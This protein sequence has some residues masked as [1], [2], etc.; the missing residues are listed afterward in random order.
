MPKAVSGF[1]QSLAPI[2]RPPFD[3]LALLVVLYY[4]WCFLVY[5]H[6][7]I[8]RGNLPDL[9]DYMYLTQL[10][11]W[12]KGQGW[13]DNI[14][15]RLNPPDGVPIHFSRLAMLPMAA[16]TLLFHLFG[17][18][19]KGAALLMSIIYPLLLLGGLLV[20]LRWLAESFVPQ[21][22]T[23]VTAYIALFATSMLYMFMLGHVDHHG[24]VIILI[25]ATLIFVMRMMKEPENPR[26]GLYAGLM[27]AFALTVA[28]EVLPWLLIIAG[29]V[30]IWATAKGRAAAYNGLAFALA[31]Y[32]GS[33]VFLT[34]TRPPDQWFVT[35]VLTYSVV[36]VLL[37]AGI[38]VGFAGVAATANAKSPVRWVVGAVLACLT[39]YLFLH[40]FPELVTGPYGGMDPELAEQLLVRDEINEVMPLITADGPLA[41]IFLYLGG[42]FVALAAGIYFLR[43]AKTEERWRLGL[44][45]ALL[46]A[47]TLLTLF[48]QRRFLG[49]LGMFT[50]IPLA[51]VL[52]RGWVRIGE[53]LEGRKKIYAEIGLLLLVGPLP[54]VFVPGL[55]DGRTFNTG[56]LLF[57]IGSSLA[58]APCDAYA[59]EK[60]L[61]DHR[62]YGDRPRLIMNSLNT[63]PEILFRTPHQVLSAPFHMD[64]SGNIDA[65]RFFSTPYP[66]EAKAIAERRHID[67]VVACRLIP[68]IY[69]RPP[70]G[71]EKV[72]TD[73]SPSRDFAP[74]FIERLMGNKAPDWLTPI[75]FHGLNNYI[76]YEV[77]LPK[78]G[79][80]NP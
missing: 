58:E 4:G 12:L 69:M 42:A 67:L 25:A 54:S 5:P 59:L 28:L 10:V 68:N 16:M 78:D 40:R 44:I 21:K 24:L 23:G 71:F 70:A 52:Q 56:V 74:H 15:Y 29:W 33:A 49:I 61:T 76:I 3:G 7:Q 17:L 13:Y 53:K 31:L 72:S 35:D 20:T 39:G 41:V 51:L 11:D 80:K 77:R 62:Y 66:S 26:W 43:R 2:F 55:I 79:A 65:T 34:L 64:V 9:D 1:F 48:Y 8:L 47:A 75:P 30:G 6:S 73:N 36:Y 32:L 19:L 60:I 45:M 27:L 46:A 50:I 63:G 57:P 18:G 37:T 38:A 14:Q 22:W